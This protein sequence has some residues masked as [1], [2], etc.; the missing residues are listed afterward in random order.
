MITPQEMGVAIL[1]ALAT[2]PIV[3]TLYVIATKLTRK[4]EPTDRC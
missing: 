3:L 2:A 4:N 1:I